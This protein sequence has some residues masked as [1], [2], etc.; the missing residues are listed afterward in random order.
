[1]DVVRLLVL[2]RCFLR[3]KTLNI[4]IFKRV[5][6]M[7]LLLKLLCISIGKS[8]SFEKVLSDLE[9]KV[10]YDLVTKQAITGICFNG[11]Q[12]LLKK[13]GELCV[14]LPVKLKIQWIGVTSMIRERNELIN[15]KCQELMERLNRD[16]MR[17]CV[18]KGQGVAA[19]YGDLSLDRQPGDIDIW[20]DGSRDRVID[21][22]MSIVPT[23]EF[24]QKHIHFHLFDNVEIEVHWIPVYRN[25]PK[26]DKILGKYFEKERDRQ[27]SNGG[28]PTVDFQLI[29][30]LLHLYSHYVYEGVGLRQMMDLYFSQN[31]CIEQMPECVTEV[32]F[33]FR[34]LGLMSFL[35]ATQW[36]I[37]TV[38]EDSQILLCEP[39]A[40]DGYKLLQEIEIGGNLGHYN[41]K[42]QVVNERLWHRFWRRWHR[43]IRMWRYD[44]IGALLMPLE[45]LKLELWMRRKRRQ[46][47]V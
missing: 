41:V 25:S 30:Q 12:N 46:Y 7:E 8:E 20:L 37:Q 32:L 17:C 16:G 5:S 13:H 45:R 31:K 27:M 1:M 23:K 15:T 35:G 44:P 6:H 26:F 18:L 36:V 29:H 28:F 2:L 4:K 38:F 40:K 10:L 11:V 19:L 14:N 33:L 3:S 43:R 39:N 34:R 42:N 47:G 24:D 22:V 21:Y 9:W